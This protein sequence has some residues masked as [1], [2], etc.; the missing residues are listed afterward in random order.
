MNLEELRT[1]ESDFVSF[2]EQFFE[3]LSN[4]VKLS[5]ERTIDY[6][7][8]LLQQEV[9]KLKNEIVNY[10]EEI[11]KYQQQLERYRK[12]ESCIQQE[13]EIISSEQLIK[14]IVRHFKNND[15]LRVQRILRYVIKYAKRY[16]EIFT[17]E[18][19]LKLFIMAYFERMDKE[20]L[21]FFPCIYTYFTVEQTLN[22]LCNLIYGENKIKLKSIRMCQSFYL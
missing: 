14:S 13:D 2:N 16:I 21:K 10:R 22:K 15:H 8:S 19:M 7:V 1:L 11:R 9:K 5:T 17:R 4:K 18:D 20:L 3:M 6:E 12:D